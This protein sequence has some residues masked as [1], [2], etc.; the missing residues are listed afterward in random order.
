M[1]PLIRFPLLALALTALHLVGLQLSFSAV[2]A[3]SPLALDW[4]PNGTVAL[5]CWFAIPAALTQAA[6]LTLPAP[7]AGEATGR[8]GLAARATLGA[9]VLTL[10]LALPVSALLDLPE[11]LEVRLSPEAGRVVLWSLI[12][13]TALT[14]VALSLLLTHRAKGEPDL[15]ERRVTQATAGTLV[16]LAL[17]TP[18]YLV[19]RRKSQCYCALGTFWALLVGL[20]SLLLVGGPLLLLMARERRT[21]AALR[22]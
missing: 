21:R 13:G 4:G 22:S 12:L 11:W 1:G 5:F 7:A 3:V 15:L 18:W 8:A 6:V 9:L 16:G 17:A 20:W 10:A 2:G 14:W 19:L